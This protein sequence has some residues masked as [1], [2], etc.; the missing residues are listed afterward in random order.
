MLAGLN[1]PVLVP[2]ES[3]SNSARLRSRGL[4]V[5]HISCAAGNRL[6]SL[7]AS[8]AT[9]R[10]PKSIPYKSASC[11]GK[12][13]DSYL[14]LYLIRREHRRMESNHMSH[15]ESIFQERSPLLRLLL[16]QAPLLTAATDWLRREGT[17]VEAMVAR[18]EQRLAARKRHLPRAHRG[19]YLAKVVL[20]EM[21]VKWHQKH[22]GRTYSSMRG[23]AQEYSLEVEP[24]LHAI[25]AMA[26]EQTFRRIVPQMVRESALRATN[27][28][29]G[30]AEEFSSFATEHV[31]LLAE[32]FLQNFDSSRMSA[33]HSAVRY[34]ERV[35][36][37]HYL[38]RRTRPIRT[39]APN[40]R[41][42]LRRSPRLHPR[43]IL[44]VKLAYLPSLLTSAEIAV[45]R[46]KYGWPGPFPRRIPIK[47]I[48]QRL[49]YSN[50]ATLS[51]KLYRVRA[52]CRSFKPSG[53]SNA[54]GEH[55]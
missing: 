27:V 37:S 16:Q 12:W 39:D 15:A 54:V 19:K 45:L 14:W 6:R 9:G 48:A 52:W 13:G 4:V 34:L 42:Y 24:L 5:S 31:E 55:Q 49:R 47:V 11:L 25:A 26:S 35:A 36:V 40:L 30:T 10:A 22:E 2:Y 32:K 51:R 23:S 21:L 44:A 28:T 29:V 33:P 43:T 50:A 46:D 3:P 8:P 18:A 41:E 7:E 17:D 38:D 1:A 53:R 20:G